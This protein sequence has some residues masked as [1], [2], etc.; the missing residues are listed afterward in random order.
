MNN[1]ASALA[2]L[3]ALPGLLGC[4]GSTEPDG[5]PTGWDSSVRLQSARDE[6]ADPHIFETN[7]TARVASAE[8]IA[9]KPTP[10]WTYEGSLPGPF[11]RAKPGDD[12]IVHFRNDLPSPTTIHWHGLRIPA[13]MD[14]TPGHS[15]DE[16]A[17]GGSFTYEFVLPDPGL[18]WYHPHFASSEQLGFGLY[19][20]L[21][22]DDPDEPEDL[23][24]EL[25]LVLSDIAVNDDGSL[26]SPDSGGDFGTLF[27]R[28]GNVL[29]VNGRSNPT[30][31]ARA[32]RRQRWR[33]VNAAKSRYFQL[34]LANHTF[35]RIGGD[36]GRIES[37]IES[38]ELVL[39]PGERADVLVVPRGAP[40][41]TL[42]VRWVPFDR[43]YGTTFNRPEE[44]LFRIHLADL[45]PVTPN[46][47]PALERQIV[48]TD[49]S[50]ATNVML[51]LTKNDVNGH[52]AMGINGIPSWDATP[53]PAMLGETQ[54]FVVKNTMDFAHPFHLHGFFFQAL[55]DSG[56]PRRPLE[57]K[58]TIDVPVGK[59]SQFVV[60]YDERPG[61]WMFH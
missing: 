5:Q 38:D 24:D 19:G 60:K 20:A 55:D 37:P 59:T 44:Q 3:I 17:P 41:S 22:V 35:T 52:L 21:L 13:T 53:L 49:P 16:V 56:S 25:V 36:G 33:I 1:I 4:G 34:A 23:G 61:M 48:P 28:E 7:L 11:V 18:Y 12:L 6:N 29:L 32:G 14:G 54:V 57:W 39:T 30:I 45:A 26:E 46:P 50:G 8:I 42:V 31:E 9:G 10:V 58:D 27:G 51:E 40:G 43:G 2:L 47:L 15:Q